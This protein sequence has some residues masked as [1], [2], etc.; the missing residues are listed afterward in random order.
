[1]SINSCSV[2]WKPSITGASF[3]IIVVYLASWC[4]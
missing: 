2:P 3:L 4:S 1:M